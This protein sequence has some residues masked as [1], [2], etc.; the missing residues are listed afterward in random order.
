[1][2]KRKKVFLILVAVVLTWHFILINGND[3]TSNT[4]PRQLV[5]VSTKEKKLRSKMT[6]LEVLE[7][8]GPASWAVLP[9]DTGEWKLPDRLI[10]LELYWENGDC[11][12]IAVDFNS[13]EQVTGWDEGQ[14]CVEGASDLVPGTAYSCRKPD[15]KRYCTIPN[16][17][18]GADTRELVR[19]V[20]N[21]LTLRDYDVGTI[22]GIYGPKTAAAIRAYQRQNGLQ[23]DGKATSQLLTRLRKGKAKRTQKVDSGTAIYLC[24]KVVRAAAKFPSKAD[25]PFLAVGVSENEGGYTVHGE[26]ELMNG[27]GLMVPHKYIC[28]VEN[29]RAKLIALS[30][31]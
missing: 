7:L 20:Q 9:S 18:A 15:R 31:G 2:S 6:R 17:A 25:F 5:S 13:A 30:P 29:R 4:N 3:S 11:A 16:V 8:L 19:Q 26:V 1:M 14:L 22:D 24:R 28:S 10:K 12:P 21:V 23:Q 27:I